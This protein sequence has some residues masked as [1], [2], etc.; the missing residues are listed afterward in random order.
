MRIH[1]L[2][3]GPIGCLLAHNLR[4]VLPAQHNITLIHKSA[5]ERQKIIKKGALWVDR[6]GVPESSSAQA[7]SHEVSVKQL[8]TLNKSATPSLT[9]DEKA[10]HATTIDSLFVA[11]KAHQ[12]LQAVKDLANRLN[13][14]STIVLFQNG[15]GIYESLIA[16]VFRNPTQRPQIVLASNS[17]GAFVKYDYHAVHA[18]VGSIEFGITPDPRGREYETGLYDETISPSKRRLRIGDI[19]SP[20]ERDAESYTNLRDTVAA[21]LLM[22]D[23]NVSWKPMSDMR[24]IMQRKLVVNA[25]INPLTAIFGC[26]NG[27]LFKNAGGRTLLQQICQEASAVYAAEVKHDNEME[28]GRL[29]QEGV[30][31]SQYQ[32]QSLPEML[33]AEAL[34]EHV[35]QV[36]HLTSGNISSM[37]QDVQRGRKTEIEFIN[38]YLESL[39]QEYRVST[40]VNATLRKL[41]KLKYHIPIDQFI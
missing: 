31:T 17:H 7:F 29:Q 25:V 18:G 16:Q 39:G 27:D 32:L 4:R 41:V 3:L 13:A 10:Q 23:L 33:T 6:K 40:P 8:Q 36:A 22:Q 11:L 38:G 2:G 37:L 30:D 5:E 20:G 19:S 28:L 15:M 24:T 26:R 35:L 34:E 1:V 14:K 9:D 21:L 12:A